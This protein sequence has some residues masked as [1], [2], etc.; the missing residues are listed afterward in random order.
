MRITI[1]VSSLDEADAARA[2]YAHSA[3]EIEIV[4]NQPTAPRPAERQPLKQPVSDR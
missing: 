2:R 4:V 1:H 3:D